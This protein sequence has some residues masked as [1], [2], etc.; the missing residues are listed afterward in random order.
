MLRTKYAVM[1]GEVLG[2]YDEAPTIQEIVR[3]FSGG[4]Q[5]VI[6]VENGKPRPLTDKEEADLQ[7]ELAKRRSHEEAYI[8]RTNDQLTPRADGELAVLGTSGR[9][10][11]LDRPL[12]NDQAP[13]SPFVRTGDVLS[14]CWRYSRVTAV[15]SWYLLR[16]TLGR[17]TDD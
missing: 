3:H 10:R 14:D 8:S 4:K 13:F 7:S 9:R 16:R 11:R 6:A 17:I 2:W 15:A 1:D 12:E 5:Y